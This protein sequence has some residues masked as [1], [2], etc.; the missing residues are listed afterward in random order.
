VRCY[1]KGEEEKTMRYTVNVFNENREVLR[2][3]ELECN[4]EDCG[5]IAVDER[6]GATR[7]ENAPADVVH[8]PGCGKQI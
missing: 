4:G 2:H 6:H 1:R 3:I 7:V 5:L 8:C